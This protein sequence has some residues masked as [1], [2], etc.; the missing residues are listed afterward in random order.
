MTGQNKRPRGLFSQRESIELRTPDSLRIDCATDPKKVGLA[1]CTMTECAPRIQEVTTGKT[2]PAIDEQVASWATTPT[3]LA[4]GEYDVATEVR[5]IDHHA[6][7]ADP[8]AEGLKPLR[9]LPDVF[10]RAK[11]RVA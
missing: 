4:L 6:L 2:W 5:Y 11:G 3:L 10:D 7:P 8:P 1:L 9:E